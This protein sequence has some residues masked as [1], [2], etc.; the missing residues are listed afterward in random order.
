M[1]A[2]RL[3]HTGDQV[4]VSGH[5]LTVLAMDRLCFARIRVTPENAQPEES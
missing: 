4:E 3:P 2:G 5:V 1:R